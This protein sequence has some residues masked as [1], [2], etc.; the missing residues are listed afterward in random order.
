MRKFYRRA[1]GLGLCV[2]LMVSFNPMS[3]ASPKNLTVPLSPLAQSPGVIALDGLQNATY[4]IPDQGS[5]TLSNGLYQQGSVTLTLIKPTAIGDVN[6]DGVNDAAVI[7]ALET[8]GSGTFEYLAIVSNQNGSLVNLDTYP[9]GD[10][11]RVQTLRIKDG[12]VR[13]KMLKHKDTDPMCCPTDLII[14]AYQLN[15]TDGTLA[16]ITLSEE[17][18][19]QVYVEDLPTPAIDNGDNG[20][21]QPPLGEFQ[22]KL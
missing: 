22:I 12:Q 9:L 4:K 13:L 11:V 16:P 18:R 10:R 19:Q 21:F 5:Y 2:G 17:Q 20:P 7:L 14:E 8:G 15:N 1:F 6:Q 3:L